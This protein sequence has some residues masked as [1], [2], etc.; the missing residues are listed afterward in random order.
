LKKRYSISQNATAL[1]KT[2]QHC[3]KRYSIA[4]NATA[5]QKTLQYFTKRYSISQNATAFQKTPQHFTK[6]LNKA[7]TVFAHGLYMFNFC[8]VSEQ[9]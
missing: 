4:K 8:P 1:Q 7:V 3:T 9:I 2:L 6:H 5:L